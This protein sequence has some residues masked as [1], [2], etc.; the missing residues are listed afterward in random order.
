MGWREKGKK[1]A[2][3]KKKKFDIYDDAVDYYKELSKTCGFVQMF[4]YIGGKRK[5]IMDTEDSK[6]E[7]FFE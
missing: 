7:C 2:P 4:E 1:T 5:W 3:V 6:N